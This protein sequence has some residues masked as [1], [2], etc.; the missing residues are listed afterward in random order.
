MKT[1]D[2]HV[3]PIDIRHLEF[4]DDKQTLSRYKKL[5]NK[6]QNGR[7]QNDTQDE[8]LDE[9]TLDDE[10]LSDETLDDHYIE[11]CTIFLNMEG[12]ANAKRLQ[13]FDLHNVKIEIDLDCRTFKVVS[14][15]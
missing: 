15:T 5:L 13:D 11:A 4:Y 2:P 6:L 9:E 14:N 12:A 7:N 8:K 10:T 3:V 1:F